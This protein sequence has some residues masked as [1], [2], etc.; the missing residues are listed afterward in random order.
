MNQDIYLVWIMPNFSK[1]TPILHLTLP[2]FTPKA[3][4]SL[5]SQARAANASSALIAQSI[6]HTHFIKKKT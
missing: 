5:D 1:T 6:G 2:Q 4:F 3:S